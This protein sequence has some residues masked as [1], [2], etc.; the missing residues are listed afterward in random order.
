MA[1]VWRCRLWLAAVIL[2]VITACSGSPNGSGSGETP[3]GQQT[4][5]SPEQ[6]AAVFDQLVEGDIGA[7]SY[8][9]LRAVLVLVGGRPLVERY[10]DS[11]TEATSNV[12]SVTKSVMSILVGVAIDE[13]V[14]GGVD[15]TLSELL[16][17][18]AAIMAPDV[19][20][21]T[22]EQVLTMTA[23]LPEDPRAARLAVLPDRG[24]GGRHSVRRAGTAAG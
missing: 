23:G 9:D 3:A 16:P 6:L 7:G 5:S 14:L 2:A 24:L 8:K 17:E 19:A 10:Y 12:A 1:R 15:Q 13:G 22:L 18:Y 21:V 4:S 11:S 20:G